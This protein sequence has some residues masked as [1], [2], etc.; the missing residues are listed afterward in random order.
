MGGRVDRDIGRGA[1]VRL[2]LGAR[3]LVA[4]IEANLTMHGETAQNYITTDL[5]NGTADAFSAP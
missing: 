3:W 2:S 5:T 4:S 1:N